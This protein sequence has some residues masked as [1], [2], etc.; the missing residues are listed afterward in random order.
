M[1]EL[2]CG[3]GEGGTGKRGQLN[4]VGKLEYRGEPEKKLPWE[5]YSS[6]VAT[7]EQK[8]KSAQHS[9]LAR[10]EVFKGRGAAGFSDR[11]RHL[12]TRIARYPDSIRETG[13]E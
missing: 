9:T 4:A 11:R 10:G 7:A 13:G 1:K 3:K 6:K 2:L 5:A 8:K 12:N